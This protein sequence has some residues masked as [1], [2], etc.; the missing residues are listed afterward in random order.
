MGIPIQVAKMLIEENKFSP[1]DGEFLTFGKQTVCVDK[2][3][4]VSLLKKNGIDHR[5]VHDFFSDGKLDTKTRHGNNT[6]EDVDFLKLFTNINYNCMD[7]SDYET[8]SIIHDLNYPVD[9]ALHEKFNF[10]FTGGCTD[11]VFNPVS[12]VMNSSRLLKHGGRVAHY[13]A[14]QGVLGAYSMISPEWWFSYYAA[15]DFDDV[16][17]YVCH[18]AEPSKN[19]LDYVTD[20]YQWQPFFTRKENFNYYDAA[21]STK[22]ILY[23]LVIAQK[24][25]GSTTDKMPVQLQYL[26]HSV[27]GWPE[28]FHTYE[29]NKRPVIRPELQR[30]HTLPFNSDHYVYL[31]S[32]F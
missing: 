28:K 18:H 10:I 7:I 21:V 27:N 12:L 8:A 20:L 24:G 16:K 29:K 15:N 32:D 3:R 30:D 4:L 13:E 11:N 26:E 9:K 22:G 25:Q 6:I 14:F 17:V 2:E 19:R 1:I 31:G 5:P 23:C